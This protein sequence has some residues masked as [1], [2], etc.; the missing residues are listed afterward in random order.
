MEIKLL[1][2]DLIQYTFEQE[3][4]LIDH[5]TGSEKSAPG[6]FER[7]SAKDVLAHNASWK[8]YRAKNIMAASADYQPLN[9]EQENSMNAEN[10]EKYCR[11]PVDEV[12]AYAR[13]ANQIL[14]QAL[15]A[16]PEKELYDSSQPWQEGRPAWRAFTS[17]GCTHPVIHMAEHKRWGSLAGQHQVQ[18]G[19]PVCP[20]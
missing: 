14:L 10:F 20:G 11:L 3:T 18:P 5:L 16:I 4:A 12:L 13:E 7:W 8:A 19:L 1:L 9:D 6:I 17:Y 15:G 2:N